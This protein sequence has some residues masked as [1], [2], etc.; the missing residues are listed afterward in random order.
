MAIDQVSTQKTTGPNSGE[1]EPVPQ[2]TI[3]YKSIIKSNEGE[4]FKLETAQ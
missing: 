3:A 4:I 1:I 2:S